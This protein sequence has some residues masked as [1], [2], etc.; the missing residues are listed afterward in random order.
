[1]I[2]IHYFAEAPV[3]LRR[4]RVSGLIRK[5]LRRR[6]FI[7]EFFVSRF[8]LFQSLKHGSY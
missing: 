7:R 6:E 8:Y 2:F 4:F 5:Q 3:L 1:M